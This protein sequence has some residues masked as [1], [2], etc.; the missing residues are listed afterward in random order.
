MPPFIAKMR[1]YVESRRRLRKVVGF[2]L[3]VAGVLGAVLP[4]LGV[5][6]IP[7]GLGLLALDYAWA[8]RW[9]EKAKGWFEHHRQGR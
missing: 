6:M 2:S 8:N 7:L 3:V 4:V 5:W 9:F 1:C